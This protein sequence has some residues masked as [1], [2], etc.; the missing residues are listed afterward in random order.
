MRPIRWYYTPMML[1]FTR[2][3]EA[4]AVVYDCMDELSNFKFAPPELRSL[5][6]ELMAEADVVFTGGFSLYEAK[7]DQHAN[8]HPFP[9][10]RR[11]R[12]LRRSPQP[13]ARPGPR[14]PGRPGPIRGWDSMAWSTSAWTWSFWPTWPT[15]GQTGPCASSARW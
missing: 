14:G 7:K 8:I 5:E 3:I 11:P 6:R 10:Q 9:F 1:G 15:P 2:H 13:H 12:P 4:S